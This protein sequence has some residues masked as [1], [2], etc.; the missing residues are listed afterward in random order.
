M[1][2]RPQRSTLFPYSTLFRSLELLG[3]EHDAEAAA[4]RNTFPVLPVVRHRRVAHSPL[5]RRADRDR[6]GL[7]AFR[8]DDRLHRVPRRAPPE[9]MRRLEL[10]ARLGYQ[11]GRASC[12]ERV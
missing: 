9:I 5:A 3:A 11:I 12:R 2:R 6:V 4:P 8:G 7:W 1:I 10:G